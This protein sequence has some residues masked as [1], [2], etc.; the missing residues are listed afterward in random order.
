MAAAKPYSSTAEHYDVPLTFTPQTTLLYGLMLAVE[1]TVGVNNLF[2]VA[3]TDC[4]LDFER[5]GPEPIARGPSF[6]RPTRLEHYLNQAFIHSTL[7]E[8]VTAYAAFNDEI[9]LELSA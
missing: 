9:E 5:F 4:N 6:P 8:R 7:A 3:I 2:H 1:A